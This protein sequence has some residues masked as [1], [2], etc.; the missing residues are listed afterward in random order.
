MAALSHIPRDEKHRLASELHNN[1]EKRAQTGPAE[2]LL[3]AMIP[4]FAASR[5]SLAQHVSD[6]AGAEATRAALLAVCDTHDDDVDRWYRH[7]YRYIEVESLRRNTAAHASIEALLQASY[8]DG[9]EHVDARIPDQNDEV[10]KTITVLREAQHA[11]I[12]AAIELPLEWLTKLEAAVQQSEASY[13]AYQ[14]SFGESKS[15]VSL[16]RDA[17]AEWVE[18]VR[19]LDHAIAF[20]SIGAEAVVVE[21]GKRLIAPLKDAIKRLRSEAKSRA[22]L[23]A[24]KDTSLPTG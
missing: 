4:K 3:D 11:Q 9:L 6:K 22:T 18:L 15:A 12:A 5:D 24:K 17:E 1:L 13:T 21:E 23:K 19:A 14:A 2:P 8:P 10:N 16:G 7:I 20:R